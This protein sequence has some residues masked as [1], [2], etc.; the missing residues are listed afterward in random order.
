MQQFNPS[1]LGDVQS[2][3][4]PKKQVHVKDTFIVSDD[5]EL[6]PSAH[7]TLKAWAIHA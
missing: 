4:C 1:T 3:S 2:F 5:L 6:A 7:F